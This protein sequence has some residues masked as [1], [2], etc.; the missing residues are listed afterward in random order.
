MAA[1]FDLGGLDWCLWGDS[2][3]G[4]DPGWSGWT[5]N[6]FGSWLFSDCALRQ[7]DDTQRIATNW[8]GGMYSA[9]LSWRNYF[10]F[11]RLG[12]HS[13]F[14][15][16]DDAAAA[17]DTFEQAYASVFVR[18][19]AESETSG[20]ALGGGYEV[21][22]NLW[23]NAINVF[24][25]DCGQPDARFKIDGGHINLTAGVPYSVGLDVYDTNLRVYVDG[26]QYGEYNLS[27]KV[28]RS[29]SIGFRTFYSDM[30]AHNLTVANRSAVIENSAAWGALSRARRR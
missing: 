9:S 29:G 10:V 1:F 23:E 22:F 30:F 25:G 21:A 5:N 16:A 28:C 20:T 24:G 7:I 13:R 3:C 18:A 8:I 11:L 12:S 2:F 26:V 4:D 14:T 6:G 19:F 15:A 17:D 27:S